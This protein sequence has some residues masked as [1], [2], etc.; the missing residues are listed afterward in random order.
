MSFHWPICKGRRQISYVSKKF[1]SP[2]VLLITGIKTFKVIRITWN[3][4]RVTPFFAKNEN[5]IPSYRKAD[6]SEIEAD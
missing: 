5:I 2:E 4:N 3:R 1:S 6:K